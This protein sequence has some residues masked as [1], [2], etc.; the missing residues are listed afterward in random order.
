MPW[1]QTLKAQITNTLGV[2][3]QLLPAYYGS[4]DLDRIDDIAYDAMKEI[5]ILRELIKVM[6]KDQKS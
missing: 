2:T 4:D 3:Q 5:V 6:K 1:D